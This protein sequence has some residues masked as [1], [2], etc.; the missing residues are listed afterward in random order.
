MYY[1]F[2]RRCSMG[3]HLRVLR[4][5]SLNKQNPAMDVYVN[6]LRDVHALH[7]FRDKQVMQRG[8]WD[9]QVPRDVKI[10]L[11][12]ADYVV[13]SENVC[14]LTEVGLSVVEYRQTEGV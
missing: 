7:K 3:R 5:K 11:V 4:N 10:R 14:Y 8:V 2:W 1:H 13:V 6:V 12:K 9:A